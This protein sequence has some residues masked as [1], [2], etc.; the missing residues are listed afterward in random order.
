[1]YLSVLINFFMLTLLLAASSLAKAE[2]DWQVLNPRAG[3]TLIS[4]DK[5]SVVLEAA[6]VTFWEKV[7]FA[8]AEEKDDVSGR[9]IKFKRVQRLMDCT[10]KTQG[11]LRGSTFGENNKLIEAI[12]LEP[13]NVVMTPIQS[14]SVAE[15]QWKLA[16]TKSNTSSV[17]PPLATPFDSSL[18]LRLS[19]E[20]DIRPPNLRTP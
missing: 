10:E 19:T 20:L 18:D 6:N 15:L 16:C 5:N 4:M 9:M 17:S 12:I 14:G 2:A 3:N 7:E 8:Q 1:M 13:A 11:V